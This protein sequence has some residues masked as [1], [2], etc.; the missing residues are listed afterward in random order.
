[1]R[2]HVLEFPGEFWLKTNIINKMRGSYLTIAMTLSKFWYPDSSSYNPEDG[3]IIVNIK[4]F[5]LI[6]LLIE[7]SK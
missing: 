2:N 3:H 1:M 6:L 5:D 4:F 7:I